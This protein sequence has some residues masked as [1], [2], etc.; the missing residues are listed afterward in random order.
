[1]L[2]SDVTEVKQKT[3]KVQDIY[4]GI[5]Y[6]PV[7]FDVER[8]EANRYPEF[9]QMGKESWIELA[10]AGKVIVINDELSDKIDNTEKKEFHRILKSLCNRHNKT[11]K[12]LKIYLNIYV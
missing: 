5:K 6:S 11:Y 1:M 4:E 3:Q 7:Q 8:E 2:T 9:E 12:S 10:K